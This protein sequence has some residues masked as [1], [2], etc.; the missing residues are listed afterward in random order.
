MSA[1]PAPS[2]AR[3]L[4]IA[5]NRRRA[6]PARR[7]RDVL[8]GQILDGAFGDGALPYERDLSQKLGVTRN[9][10][11]D[12]LDLLRREGLIERIPGAGTFVVA[13][14]SSQ[15]LD[16]LRGLA[17]TFTGSEDWVVNQVL[18]AEITGAPAFVADRL[19]LGAGDPV[20]FIERLRHLR[21]QPLS[22]DASYLDASVA[23]GLLDE[24]LVAND[25]YVLLERELGLPLASAELSIEA[26]S[27]DASTA[28]LLG[29]VAGSPL[30][31]LER[32][33]M[34]DDGRPIDFEFVRY[35]GDRLS[36]TAHLDRSH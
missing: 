25:V 19:G 16:Q 14:K 31:L 24:D 28:A 7:V 23:A 4:R 29:V 10:V 11:R 21:G 32:L 8:R 35:R 1:A 5:T 13:H 34:L 17:E 15:G 20:V 33:A 36:L 2:D 12:A 6:D 22:L 30:L 26:V 3:P 18:A 27:A 9:V